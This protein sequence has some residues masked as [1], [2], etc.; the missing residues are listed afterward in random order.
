MRPL[1]E[2]D[3]LKIAGLICEALQHMHDPGIIHRAVFLLVRGACRS[4]LSNSSHVS[5]EGS[6][7]LKQLQSNPMCW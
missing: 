6:L 7:W 3:A 2:K 1:P 4:A 5:A